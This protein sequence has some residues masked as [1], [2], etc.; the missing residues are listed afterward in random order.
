[1][2]IHWQALEEHFLMVPQVKMYFLNFSPK[3]PVLKAGN[4]LTTN[5]CFLMPTKKR[6]LAT[7]CATHCCGKTHVFCCVLPQA[8][9]IGLILRGDHRILPQGVAYQP[10]VRSTRQK[11]LD[12]A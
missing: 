3:K 1:M 6:C 9:K 11:P 8:Y 5:S 2:T 12:A 4:T 7:W 10:R